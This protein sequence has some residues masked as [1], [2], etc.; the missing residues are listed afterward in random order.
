MSGIDLES[1]VIGAGASDEF[2]PEEIASALAAPSPAA[3]AGQALDLDTGPEIDPETPEIIPPEV[4]AEQW[5]VLHEVAGGMISASCGGAP[6]PLGDQARGDGGQIA[7]RATYD[8]I[9][10]QPWLAKIMLSPNGGALANS[11]A[12]LAHGFA[13]VQIVRAARAMPVSQ[14]GAAT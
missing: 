11:L 4:W 13:C 14:P 8:L 6:C 10:S 1:A 7:A 3:D 12:I 2:R 5:T 9:A